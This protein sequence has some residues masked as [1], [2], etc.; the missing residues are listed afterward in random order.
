MRMAPVDAARKLSEGLS[1]LGLGA[2]PAKEVLLLRYLELLAKWNR[3]YNLTAID[4]PLEMVSRHLL[5]SLAVVPHLRGRRILD[6]GSG[7]GLPGIPLAIWCPDLELHLLDSNGK[8]IRFLFQVRLSL[9][10]VNVTLHH[11]RAEALEDMPGFDSIVSRAFASLAA[12]IDVGGHLL[13]PGGCFLAMKGNLG[14]D[15]LLAVPAPYTVASRTTLAIPGVSGE[16]QLL[17]ITRQGI[18]AK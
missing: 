13:A 15:E 6:L 18:T 12:M 9:A 3:T 2:D 7:A 17:R 5:D 16:R 14:E 8:K 11:S 10:L 4:D 1:S